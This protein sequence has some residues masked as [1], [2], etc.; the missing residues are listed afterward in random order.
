MTDI[1]AYLSF[2]LTLFLAFGVAFET[3]VAVV[4]LVAMDMVSTKTLVASRAYVIVGAFVVGMVLTPPDVISQFLMA[5]PMW[6]LFEVGVLFARV[7][8]KRR[9]APA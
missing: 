7:I 4:L 1:E 5:L 9:A 2:V 8:E 3:P 6:L